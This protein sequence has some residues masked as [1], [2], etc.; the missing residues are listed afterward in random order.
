[1][2]FKEW[3]EHVFNPE[4]KEFDD[5]ET[6]KPLKEQFN[7]MLSE[8]SSEVN[9]ILG[10]KAENRNSSKGG[11]RTPEMV[12]LM[13]AVSLGAV[14]LPVVAK[15]FGLG[16][17]TSLSG[18]VFAVSLGL[19]IV[20]AGV[21]IVK[22]IISVAKAHQINK[23]NI[24][25]ALAEVDSYIEKLE[26]ATKKSQDRLDQ[27]LEDIYQNGETK[28]SILSSEDLINVKI[29]AELIPWLKN[30]AR[31][32]RRAPTAS[33]IKEKIKDI[34]DNYYRELFVSQLISEKVKPLNSEIEELKSDIEE[35]EA[36]IKEL[37]DQQ[38]KDIDIN[39][40][41]NL[42][43]QVSDIEKDIKDKQK[44]I[45]QLEDEVLAVSTNGLSQFG[46]DKNEDEIADILRDDQE[47]VSRAV[48]EMLSVLDLEDKEKINQELK[49]TAKAAINGVNAQIKRHRLNAY[50]ANN[51]IEEHNQLVPIYNNI[52]QEYSQYS[53]PVP[54]VVP[55]SSGYDKKA[56]F[57]LG[58]IVVGVGL[59]V[60][61]AADTKGS[62]DDADSQ[63]IVPALEQAKEATTF[64]LARLIGQEPVMQEQTL[65]SQEPLAPVEEKDSPMPAPQTAV[66][67][68]SD[69]DEGIT[70]EADEVEREEEE[71]KV[72]E[73]EGESAKPAELTPTTGVDPPAVTIDLESRIQ[74]L[75]RQITATRT[76]LE[77]N[78]ESASD[79]RAEELVGIDEA[80]RDL[81]NVSRK[82]REYKKLRDIQENLPVS[83]PD[84]PRLSEVLFTYDASL[85]II[86]QIERGNLDRAA[87]VIETY[88][89]Y[90]YNE[91]QGLPKG[92][93]VRKAVVYEGEQAAGANAWF[94]TA[95]ARYLDAKDSLT[96]Q[97]R[98]F[99][100]MMTGIAD[101]LVDSQ[102]SEN[103]SPA[104]GALPTCKGGNY[105]STEHNISTR[106]A[107]NLL[108]NLINNNA[109]LSGYANRIPTYQEA[110]RGIEQFLTRTV[111]VKKYDGTIV[112][113]EI[114][115]PILRL[116]QD[117]RLLGIPIYSAKDYY[118]RRGYRQGEG[119]EDT[120]ATDLALWAVMSI[121]DQDFERIYGQDRD[122]FVKDA[123]KLSRVEVEVDGQELDLLDFTDEQG[124]RDS[125]RAG[126]PADWL[127]RLSGRSEGR[128]EEERTMGWLEGTSF[129]AAA[130]RSVGQERDAAKLLADVAATIGEGGTIPYATRRGEPTGHGWYTP[131]GRKALSSTT[132]FELASNNVNPFRLNSAG[133]DKKLVNLEAF[134]YG[135]DQEAFVGAM[136]TYIRDSLAELREEVE[137]VENIEDPRTK[138]ELFKLN[139]S[140]NHIAGSFM[141]NLPIGGDFGAGLNGGGLIG[142]SANLGFTVSGLVEGSTFAPLSGYV[143][144]DQLIDLTWGNYLMQK[145]AREGA[146]LYIPSNRD[147]G[148]DIKVLDFFNGLREPLK[149]ELLNTVEIGMEV[150]VFEIGDRQ[151]FKPDLKLPLEDIFNQYYPAIV[152]PSEAMRFAYYEAVFSPEDNCNYFMARLGEDKF[153]VRYNYEQGS[154][155]GLARQRFFIPETQQFLQNYNLWM[156]D[157]QILPISN[158][159]SLQNAPDYLR[160]MTSH[161]GV[162]VDIN[163]GEAN[164]IKSSQEVGF[165]VEV[166]TE[167][168]YPIFFEIHTGNIIIPGLK[169]TLLESALR[170]KQTV[171]YPTSM[172][173]FRVNDMPEA[174]VIGLDSSYYIFDAK[175]L[176][177][178]P[179]VELEHDYR[180]VFG[181]R[182]IEFKKD[183]IVTFQRP[184]AQEVEIDGRTIIIPAI[185]EFGQDKDAED[186]FAVLDGG[187]KVYKESFPTLTYQE[188]ID[189]ATHQDFWDSWVA[190]YDQLIEGKVDVFNFIDIPEVSIERRVSAQETGFGFRPFEYKVN[191]GWPATGEQ[192]LVDSGDWER[193][194][195]ISLFDFAEGSL[196]RKP[197]LDFEDG[198]MVGRETIPAELREKFQDYILVQQP[199]TEVPE[200]REESTNL[201]LAR[202]L[203]EDGTFGTVLNRRPLNEAQMEALEAG[204]GLA[205]TTDGRVIILD[206]ASYGKAGLLEDYTDRFAAELS[207]QGVE[208]KK[209]GDNYQVVAKDRAPIVLPE[210]V[211][212]ALV[213]VDGDSFG[214]IQ[215]GKAYYQL[216][217]QMLAG[218]GAVQDGDKGFVNLSA[219]ELEKALR[220]GHVAARETEETRNGEPLYR[221]EVVGSNGLNGQ[222]HLGAEGTELMNNLSKTLYTLPIA[223]D[224]GNFRL[225]TEAE[226]AEI[227]DSGEVISV[228]HNGQ[229]ILAVEYQEDMAA[230]IT[231]DGKDYAPVGVPVSAMEERLSFLRGETDYIALINVARDGKLN[232]RLDKADLRALYSEEGWQGHKVVVSHQ[233]DQQQD[234]YPYINRDGEI[235]YLDAKDQILPNKRPL[236][237]LRVTY[238][239]GE[240]PTMELNQDGKDLINELLSNNYSVVS[241]ENKPSYVLSPTELMTERDRLLEQIVENKIIIVKFG[242]NGFEDLRIYLNENE[243]ERIDSETESTIFALEADGTFNEDKPIAYTERIGQIILSDGSKINL[244][245]R[246]GKDS[247]VFGV[248]SQTGEEVL[249]VRKSDGNGYIALVDLDQKTENLPEEI[250]LQL[251]L[252]GEE[253]YVAIYRWNNDR[254][255]FVRPF[256]QLGWAINFGQNSLEVNGRT[257]EFELM[258]QI[259]TNGEIV[260]VFGIDQNLNE[261]RI[262][263]NES[264]FEIL[265]TREDGREGYDTYIVEA[266]GNNTYRAIQ[267]LSSSTSL[268]YEELSQQI[269]TALEER[270]NNIAAL[271]PDSQLPNLE[272]ENTEWARIRMLTPDGAEIN[273]SLQAFV[274]SQDPVVD[275]DEN[276]LADITITYR[277]REISLRYDLDSESRLPVALSCHVSETRTLVIDFYK[278][279][280]FIEERDS[281]DKYLTQV[282]HI[283]TNGFGSRLFDVERLNRLI[284]T[285]GTFDLTREELESGLPGGLIIDRRQSLSY[286]GENSAL[287]KVF[288]IPSNVKTYYRLRNG[289]VHEILISQ[290]Q[291]QQIHWDNLMIESLNRVSVFQDSIGDLSLGEYQ[292]RTWRDFNGNVRIQVNYEANGVQKPSLATVVFDFDKYG[293]GRNSF[294]LTHT[295]DGWF[296]TSRAQMQGREQELFMFEVINGVFGEVSIN[297]DEIDNQ[298]KNLE[299][300]LERTPSELKGISVLAKNGEGR[301]KVSRT[302]YRVR[303]IN[304]GYQRVGNPEYIM[305]AF[306]NVEVVNAFEAGPLHLGHGSHSY[307]Y[308]YEAEKG[309]NYDNY[310][311]QEWLAHMEFKDISENFRINYNIT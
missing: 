22:L 117:T 38:A 127:D 167:T 157:G 283:R 159:T 175:N 260:R 54:V 138:F 92:I 223:G 134:E 131:L 306:H 147:R 56:L 31:Y 240:R 261:I 12:K 64:G 286:Q 183:T 231:I 282:W 108:I 115:L 136:M 177:R 148:L 50:K 213:Y 128:V 109:E 143:A 287:L 152:I 198:F 97:D 82:L 247:R 87:E 15:F 187:S 140:L 170:T 91:G 258:R 191:L 205:Y 61:V 281:S 124:R 33:Q 135:F 160:G 161:F 65:N 262:K 81:E 208:L 265:V 53:R 47:A 32:Y 225:T 18:I 74:R 130:L 253:S 100:Q 98:V 193:S 219:A 211:L 280:A 7:A 224:R 67:V 107:L 141:H 13:G 99:A 293:V 189:W 221:F 118:F 290:G 21:G 153:I 80:V 29:A 90:F 241:L 303:R 277:D 278:R 129:A 158:I 181:D 106:A 119:W 186:R 5:K 111:L 202:G 236:Y 289:K 73:E 72:V 188:S 194:F 37:I 16:F 171:S 207:Q 133:Q 311:N 51:Q 222:L 214:F 250:K 28:E 217:S 149:I 126:Q 279:L 79:D 264:V 125:G 96:A 1:M 200:F 309:I 68:R 267:K 291:L 259:N 172:G 294:V 274:D 185:V 104:F 212:E 45:S 238:P 288:E 24:K 44:Q 27:E 305:F 88:R 20:F 55:V 174:R 244:L 77:S 142:D 248:D 42:K 2:T 57:A 43:N 70:A 103:S 271:L 295:N 137:N 257:I 63:F 166:Q 216:R 220:R 243:V 229:W 269:Q 86:A 284:A 25:N 144:L 105:Y 89:K 83:Y 302:G 146:I 235:T 242:P 122:D 218:V 285:I 46:E 301:L 308:G 192:D 203:W 4:V 268:D 11:F 110:I 23:Q 62:F 182:D 113:L 275:I 3:L 112:N 273:S 34:F 204:F 245:E 168:P 60:A 263:I 139:L 17:I 270:M 209:V 228:K 307:I 14:L 246:T 298:Y 93:N 154:I 239:N 234:G 299:E 162:K 40:V 30:F 237:T 132:W 101:S 196:K 19:G 190:G 76:R 58:L 163:T 52:V 155:E 197:N 39:Q 226:L 66:E 296:M 10:E 121:G 195:S 300:L 9:S 233:R 184:F 201:E 180:L 123:V 292:Y 178:L 255:D 232:V 169:G 26:E 176:E 156:K 59:P 120:F 94:A 227:M 179:T 84:D 71:A 165:S 230:K 85:Y 75:E 69:L 256:E 151:Y 215:P 276:N 252:T 78:I 266:A 114:I 164:I 6:E 102:N 35:L 206:A 150:P 95:I 199:L 36:K 49:D 210:K 173:T 8:V 254:N 48:T 297:I 145:S 272:G 251:G 116:G 304:S 310:E 41:S 249:R